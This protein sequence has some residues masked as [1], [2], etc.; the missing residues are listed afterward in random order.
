MNPKERGIHS[1]RVD[2]AK[3]LLAAAE[4]ETVTI[5]SGQASISLRV[6]DALRR[7]VAAFG[8]RADRWVLP[9]NT[10]LPFESTFRPEE[11]REG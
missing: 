10:G 3:A 1:I 7:V 8:S 5:E 11:V 6:Q 4:E 2:V 9:V